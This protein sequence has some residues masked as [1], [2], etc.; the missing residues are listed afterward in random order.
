MADIAAR[1]AEEQKAMDEFIAK[2]TPP[3]SAM[4]RAEV[5]E[6]ARTQ[7][8]QSPD[9]VKGDVAPDF[10]LPVFDFSSGTRVETGEVF[11]LQSVAANTPVALVFGS[12]T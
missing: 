11:H 12:Y 7:R 10:E 1:S 4:T 6:L 9:V 8:L 3:D 5:A 2:I